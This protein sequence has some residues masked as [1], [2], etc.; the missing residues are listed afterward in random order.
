MPVETNIVIAECEEG[1]NLTGFIEKMKAE[2]ILFFSIS[3]TKFR[4][5]THLD[6]DRDMIEKLIH[7]IKN[8]D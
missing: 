5:V 7:T 1:F 6:V 4:M 3:P 8:T 2:G